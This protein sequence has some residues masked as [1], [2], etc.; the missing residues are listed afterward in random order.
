MVGD[1][2]DEKIVTTGKVSDL[3]LDFESSLLKG[4]QVSMLVTISAVS[5]FNNRL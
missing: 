2:R 4:S 1:V 3:S 5:D